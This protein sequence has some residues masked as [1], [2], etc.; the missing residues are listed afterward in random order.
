[1][2][3]R[4]VLV[5]GLGASTRWW[6]SVLP[7]LRD[8]DVVYGDPR[9]E[10]DVDDDAILVGHSLGG[11]RAAQYAARQ[12]V[13]K[14]V[15]VAPAGIPWG[16][17]FVVDALN[18]F[19]QA[20]ARFMPIVAFDSLR[21]GP[22]ALLRYGLE[23]SRTRVDLA[24]IEAPTLIVWGERDNLVPVRVAIEWHEAIPQA[25]LEIVPG[26]RHVPMVE[27]TSAFVEVLLDFLRDDGGSGVVHGVGLAGHD[28][29]PP[30]R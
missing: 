12:R 9:R 15:L 4:L 13:R 2:H 3:N 8:Y 10:L 27:N 19:N 1:V 25:R 21:W 20:P 16:R 7:A 11:L 6:R 18:M 26:A 23:A 24:S 28:D 14:L 30:A 29:G 17:R 22:L 5:H